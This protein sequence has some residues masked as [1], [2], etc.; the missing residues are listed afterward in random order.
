M[1]VQ[2]MGSKEPSAFADFLF[3]SMFLVNNIEYATYDSNDKDHSKKV[4]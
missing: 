1:S 2:T 3:Y 4:D